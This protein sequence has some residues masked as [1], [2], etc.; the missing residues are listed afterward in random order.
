MADRRVAIVTGASRGL[1]RALALAL[2]GEGVHVALGARSE[3]DLMAVADEV[4]ALG[5]EA[6]AVP[7][8]VTVAEDVRNLVDQTV[9]QLGA[10]DILINNSGVYQEVSLL[11]MTVPEWDRIID[12]DLKGTYLCTQAVARRMVE[13]GVGGKVINV[14]SIFAHKGTARYSAYCAAKAAVVGFTKAVAVELARFN[15]QVNAMAPGY[16]ETAMNEYLRDDPDLYERALRK[17][18]LHRMGLPSELGPLA[19]FL[20]SSGSDYITGQSFIIDGGYSVR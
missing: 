11:E 2:A 8:D 15:I 18:P 4:R 10:V 1:G 17:I 19:L 5:S 12:T 3:G 13:R 9:D 6:I 16:F 20:T 14:T 7:T